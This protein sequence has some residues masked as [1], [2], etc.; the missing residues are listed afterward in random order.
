M[1]VPFFVLRVVKII[2]RVW[3]EGRD[4]VRN[5]S[6]RRQ[7]IEKPRPL[8]FFLRKRREVSPYCTRLFVLIGIAQDQGRLNVNCARQWEEQTIP[9][10][11]SD[12]H[13]QLVLEVLLT[14]VWH[15]GLW[16]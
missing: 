16:L 8:E 1:S 4:E 3:C 10:G 11:T 9:V 6:A 15:G 5:S 2:V 7:Q 13:K 14:L 12:Q